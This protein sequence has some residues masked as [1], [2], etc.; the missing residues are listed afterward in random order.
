MPK[1]PDESQSLSPV[2]TGQEP[3]DPPA[4]SPVVLA[5]IVAEAILEAIGK[6]H[7]CEWTILA[8]AYLKPASPGRPAHSRIGRAPEGLT[9]VLYRCQK[10]RVLYVQ[11]L[12]GQWE[13][14]TLVGE[15][16]PAP[17]GE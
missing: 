13:A 8:I 1:I 6:V 17:L 14:G 2:P 9:R 5:H 3:L 7:D 10:C 12:P 11:E 4:D 15:E 16:P